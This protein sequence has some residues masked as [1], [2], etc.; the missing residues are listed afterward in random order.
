MWLQMHRLLG[1]SEPVL[2]F[3]QKRQQQSLADL[4][5]LQQL[6]RRTADLERLVLQAQALGFRPG[7]GDNSAPGA[8]G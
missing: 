6:R 2:D 5:E 7:E 3:L 8:Q 1:A 4:Q